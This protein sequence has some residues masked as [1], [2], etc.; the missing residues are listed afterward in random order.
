MEAGRAVSSPPSAP[1]KRGSWLGLRSAGR[2]WRSAQ[3]WDKSWQLWLPRSSDGLDMEGVERVKMGLNF[4]GFV[5][6]T[7]WVM[8]PLYG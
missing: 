1:G 6:A 4:Q 8:D 3:T 2:G 5:L 7:R